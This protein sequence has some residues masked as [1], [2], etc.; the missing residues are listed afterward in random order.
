MAMKGCSTFLKAP[1]CLVSY[2]E[3]SLVEG[4][5]SPLQ[6]C[7]RCILQPQPTGQINLLY[8][9]MPYH[10][11]T[12]I[13]TQKDFFINICVPLTLF[14]RVRKGYSRFAC[15][16]VLETEQKLQYF[17]PYSYGRQ[18]CVFLVLLMLN[19]RPRGPFCWMM[20]FFTVY[21]QH[22]LCTPTHQGPKPLRPG[23]V[24]PTISRL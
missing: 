19:R 15:E 16:R 4:S 22:L 5:Y 13:K 2:P 18:R 6:M 21:Y 20:A 3:H 23:V 17:D 9:H 11:D 14:V 10:N 12:I 1:D 7:C 8:S 24:F